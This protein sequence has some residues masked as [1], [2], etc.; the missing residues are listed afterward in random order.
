MVGSC[1]VPFVGQGQ[2]NPTA[3]SIIVRTTGPDGLI[4]YG[5]N[6]QV[7]ISLL[8]DFKSLVICSVGGPD[9]RPFVDDKVSIVLWT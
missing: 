8:N 1:Q 7:C 2:T 9:W 3:M 4:V 5:V 6:D